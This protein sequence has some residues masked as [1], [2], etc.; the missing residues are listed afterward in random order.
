MVRLLAER[1]GPNAWTPLPGDLSLLEEELLVVPVSSGEDGEQRA[2]DIDPDE[3]LDGA[4]E[5][6]EV[7]RGE[8]L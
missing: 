2:R 5:L 7:V 8:I 4:T 3:R 6:T 1:G